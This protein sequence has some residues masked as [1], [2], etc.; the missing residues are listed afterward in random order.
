MTEFTFL[1]KRFYT[2]LFA[3][4]V[5]N[6]ELDLLILKRLADIKGVDIVTF[7]EESLHDMSAQKSTATDD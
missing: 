4:K 3:T 2:H 7:G 1:L 5:T 6:E